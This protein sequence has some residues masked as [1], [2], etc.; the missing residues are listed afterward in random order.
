MLSIIGGLYLAKALYHYQK[1]SKKIEMPLGGTYAV[2]TGAT[3]GIGRQFALQ[4]S[5]EYNLILLGRNLKETEDDILRYSPS[6]KIV[7]ISIDFSLTNADI[8]DEIKKR[9]KTFSVSILVNNVASRS[10]NFSSL[11]KQLDTI[12]VGTKPMVILTEIFREACETS[13][14]IINVTAQSSHSTHLVASE[15]DL[16]LPYLSVYEAT[17]EFGNSF[18]R[19]I[20]EYMKQNQENIQVVTVKPGAVQTSRTK[21]FFQGMSRLFSVSDKDFVR[22]VLENLREDVSVYTWKHKLSNFL[23]DCFPCIKKKVL[24]QT[25]KR[26]ASKI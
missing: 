17:N 25:S 4:L 10:G 14:L 5:K 18:S 1:P 23:M 9:M 13:G 24:T 8:Y 15:G 11:Q 16:N 7:C 3:S 19:S 2:V 22:N 12:V 21:D 6:C 26:I 20:R